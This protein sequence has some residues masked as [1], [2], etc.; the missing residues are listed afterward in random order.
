MDHTGLRGVTT[1]LP[2]SPMRDRKL[3]IQSWIP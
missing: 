3:L 2:V 1:D